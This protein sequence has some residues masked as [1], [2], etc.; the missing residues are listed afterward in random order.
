[1]TMGPRLRKAALTAHVAASVGWLGAVV[2]F[3]G[4]AVVGLTSGDAQ[5]VRGAYL[6]ME[7]AGWYVLVPLGLLSLLTGL[8]QSLG[9]HWGLFR[10]YWVLAKLSINVVATIV[11]L[12]Y[13]QTL[14]YL[15]D[16]A[17]ETTGDDLAALRSA[18]PLL[19]AG[20]ALLL[21]L[22]ATTLSVVKPR[23]MTRYGQRRQQQRLGR[24]AG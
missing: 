12:L 21:L 16:V 2:V 18:S 22:M 5:T 7:P 24:R 6:V 13:M 1:M 17:A 20:A 4:L 9:T 3:V 10:H 23:G 15:A 8:V 19:H 14:G 11:L